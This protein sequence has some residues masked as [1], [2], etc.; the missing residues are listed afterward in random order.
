MNARDT[1]RHTAQLTEGRRPVWLP[2][3]AGPHEE[4]A[5]AVL[6]SLTEFRADAWRY[7][8]GMGWIALG[9]RSGWYGLPG[10]VGLYLWADVPRLCVGS[11]SVWTDEAD[12]QRWIGLP[13]HVHVMRRYRPRGKARSTQW[14]CETFDRTVILAEAKRRLACGEL[15]S[16]EDLATPT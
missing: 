1:Q 13:R 14:T 16:H 4:T 5:G 9:L 12:L 7:F 15:F 2:W 11:L 8:P 6:V 3:I 10:A